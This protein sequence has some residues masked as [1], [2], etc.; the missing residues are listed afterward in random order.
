MIYDSDMFKCDLRDETTNRNKNPDGGK[1]LNF[2][3]L[4]V[5]QGGVS[6]GEKNDHT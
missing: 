3:V 2:H 6:L 4:D 5:M 1:F